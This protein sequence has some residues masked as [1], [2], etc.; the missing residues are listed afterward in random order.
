MFTSTLR[1]EEKCVGSNERD[2]IYTFVCMCNELIVHILVCSVQQ[3]IVRAWRL[4]IMTCEEALLDKK[5]PAEK[6]DS[7]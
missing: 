1:K 7:G 2:I 4:S 5:M 3:Y 6:A